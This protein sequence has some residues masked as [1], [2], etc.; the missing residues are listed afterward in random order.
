M[1]A[2]VM[3]AIILLLAGTMVATPNNQA[4]L[5]LH[6]QEI[7]IKTADNLKLYAWLTP[8]PDKHAPL[9]VLLPMMGR[10]HT[11]YNDFIKALYDKL[12]PSDT[13]KKAMHKIPNILT[14]DLR[15]HGKSTTLGKATIGF[16][17]MSP[18]DFQKYPQDIQE[19]ITHILNDTTYDIDKNNIV[20]IG[21]SIGANT[22]IMVPALVK[23]VKQVVM[24]SPGENYRSLEP[25]NYL[26]KYQGKV[27]ICASE[28]DGY[29]S[30]SS[31][32]L[33]KLNNNC[34]LKIYPGS[35]HGTNII[36]NHPQTMTYLLDWLFK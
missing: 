27:L 7:T 29:A 30:E 10:T 14:F 26:K 12:T 11:S 24:L 20:V 33:A 13:G 15:G 35:N 18:E 19:M 32:K 2:T 3:I 16:R 17:S 1:K 34:T 22:A 23:N 8:S 21:A 4:N 25:A 5:K 28:E 9:Y 36:N 31:K 6:Q